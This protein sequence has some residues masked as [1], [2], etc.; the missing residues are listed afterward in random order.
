MLNLVGRSVRVS[1]TSIAIPLLGV[2]AVALVACGSSSSDTAS[3][4]SDLSAPGAGPS[5]TLIY[6]PQHPQP[7]LEKNVDATEAD[8]VLH[9]LFPSFLT[10]ADDCAT[11]VRDL[12]DAR[13]RGQFVPSVDTKLQGAFTASGKNETVYLL[14]LNECGAPHSEDFGSAMFAVNDDSSFTVKAILD[15]QGSTA[16]HRVIDAGNGTK[17]LVLTQGSTGQGE[18]DELVKLAKITTAGVTVVKDFNTVYT[19][20]CGTDEQPLQENFSIITQVLKAGGGVDFTLDKR[21][22]GCQAR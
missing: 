22:A 7:G 5:P 14:K 19:D 4:G 17:E 8:G 13:N 21:T 18:T 6:D 16:V 1:R 2:V 10:N 3:G 15:G 9:R 12:E 11:D 20:N